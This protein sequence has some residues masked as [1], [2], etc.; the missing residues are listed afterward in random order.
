M[1]LNLLPVNPLSSANFINPAIGSEPAERMKRRGVVALESLQIK[2]SEEKIKRGFIK[3]GDTLLS[4][5]RFVI[6]MTS[7]RVFLHFC[8]GHRHT[9]QELSSGKSSLERILKKNQKFIICSFIKHE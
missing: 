2:E 8:A 4:D 6:R 1:E 3:L 5:R 7:L 9:N